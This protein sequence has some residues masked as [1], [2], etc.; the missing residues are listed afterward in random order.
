MN[1][2][3]IKNAFKKHAN[4]SCYSGKGCFV[5]VPKSDLLPLFQQG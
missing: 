1:Y 3:N 4:R 5:D 2:S